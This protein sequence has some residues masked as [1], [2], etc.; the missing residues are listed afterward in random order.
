MNTSHAYDINILG[1]KS[2]MFKSSST[3]GVMVIGVGQLT[4]VSLSQ[5]RYRL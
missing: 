2:E 5:P 3:C 1:S 4:E